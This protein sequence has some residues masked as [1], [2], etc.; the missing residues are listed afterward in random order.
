MQ[1]GVMRACISSL[2]KLFSTRSVIIVSEHKIGHHQVSGKSQLLIAATVIGFFSCI[3]YMSGSYMAAQSQLSE[4]D[5]MLQQANE[6]KNRIDEEFALL[7]R[8]LAK[9]S[10]NG[11]QLSEYSQFIMNSH[12]GE[13]ESGD[14]IINAHSLMSS[15]ED[16]PMLS[17]ISFLEKQIEEIQSENDQLIAAIR[18]RTDNKLEYFEDIIDTT[19]LNISSLEKQASN[20]RDKSKSEN[21][22]SVENQGGPFIAFDAATFD[23]EEKELIGDI[24]RLMLLRDIVQTL[25]TSNP[26]KNAQLM[27]GF[28]VRSDPFNG[29]AAMHT[30]LDLSGP[31]GSS[32]Y[33]ANTG[34]I[35]AAEWKSA[36]GNTVDIDHGLGITTRY[37]HLSQILVKEGD[38]VR[39]GQIIGIQ[40]STGRSTGPHLHYEVRYNDRPLN[41]A[42]F[43]KAGEY[44]SQK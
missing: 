19:G 28:G 34:R 15:G 36:Y 13:A 3:S 22:K 40:G 42:K 27:S 31:S 18:E 35:I 9:F 1:K 23:K 41:P 17:R 20:L 30:G 10:K 16:S 14:A 33:A 5:K 2:K 26:I 29:H 32:I 44:V 38:R 25:P 11:K 43:L 24:D 8:D 4:K 6:D 39:K 7:K 21:E 37:G 12:F